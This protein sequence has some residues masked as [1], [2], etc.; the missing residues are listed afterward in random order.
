[1]QDDGPGSK[2]P[3]PCK[4]KKTADLH[5]GVFNMALTLSPPSELLAVAGLQT[6]F[7]S[8]GIDNTSRDDLA[9]FAISEGA[10]VSATFTSNRFAAAP[11]TVAREHSKR[12]HIR[13]LLINA[14]N[15]NAGTGERGIADALRL[16]QALAEQT[17]CD[18]DRILPFSTGV[19][20]EYLPVNNIIDTLPTLVGGLSNNNWL[21]C[22]RAIMTTDTKAKG[23][24]EQLRIDDTLITLTGIAKGS[25]M[26][27][28]DMGTLL[29]FMATDAH[30]D[31]AILDR[32]WQSC[33]SKTFN[34]IC[35]DGDTSTNDACVLIATGKAAMER[36]TDSD[37][38]A[39]TLLEE[40]VHGLCLK[41]AK[42]I[43]R[44][45]EGATKFITIHVNHAENEAQCTAIAHA[46]ST[47]PLVKTAFYGSD[48]NWGRILAA[49]GRSHIEGLDVDHVCVYLDDVCVVR[50]GARAADYTEE[51]GNRIMQKEAILLSVD[52]RMGDVSGEF[53]TC[54][55]SHEYVSINTEYRT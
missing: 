43:V 6:A 36:I 20:G 4:D 9:L 23:F 12:N 11:V 3:M 8:A 40:R 38:H 7:A 27:N 22:A 26:I 48:P 42:A 19:I 15:A 31:K 18:L 16:C 50:N 14:G 28:P 45:A 17:G 32:I 55:L 21:G 49:I 47:S 24:S 25:G 13:Y 1:M 30:V 5:G 54:D 51:K 52:L 29:A 41:L 46:L 35:V 37:H 2:G 53:W 10:T 39:C 33:I 44:D 34:R